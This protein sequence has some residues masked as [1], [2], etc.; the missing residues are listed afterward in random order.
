[1]PLNYKELIEARFEEVRHS[2]TRRDT[3]LYALGIGFG[4]DPLDGDELRFVYEKD[5]QAFPTMSCILGALSGWM[6]EPRFGIDWLKVLHGQE[7]LQVFAPLPV[8]GAVIGRMRVSDVIDKG[9]DRGALILHERDVIDAATGDLLARRTATLFA[10]GD[11][12]CGGSGKEAAAPLPV[13]ASAPDVVIE[14]ATRPEAALLYRLN[15]D[16]IPM[17]VDP[18]VA[19]KAGFDGPIL[20]GLCTYAMGGRAIVRALCGGDAGRLRRLTG[21]FTSVVY[22]G[23]TIRTEIWRDGSNASYRQSVVERGKVVVDHG[24]AELA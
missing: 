16:Y 5:L 8:E 6:R 7:D 11:G 3:M 14:F 2:Y 21:R 10:R 19:R 13:P 22:P 23:E 12:G 4:Q 17:H 18:V 24:R 15:G 1:M 20:H 9:P